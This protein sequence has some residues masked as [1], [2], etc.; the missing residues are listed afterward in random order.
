MESN[1]LI[2]PALP[3]VFKKK[4]NEEDSDDETACTCER[5]VYCYR[6]HITVVIVSIMITLS[7]FFI[8]SG[9]ALPPGYKRAV[10]SSSS[11]DSDQEVT[12]KRSKTTHTRSDKSTEK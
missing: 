12:S 11:D 10:H 8:D 6:R 3:P 2:G 4:E 5:N 9:P 7:C 1:T